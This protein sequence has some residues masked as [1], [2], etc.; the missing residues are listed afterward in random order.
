MY[1]YKNYDELS[2]ES[3]VINY[4]DGIKVPT[5]SLQAKDDGMFTDEFTPRK[6]SQK[7]NSKVCIGVTDFGMHCCHITG[8]LIPTYWSPKPCME[9]IE[10]LETKKRPLI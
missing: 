6:R 3:S 5:F 10:F 8:W 4:F 9:F 7:R 2:Y 1:G